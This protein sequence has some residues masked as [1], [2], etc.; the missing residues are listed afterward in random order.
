MA[1]A[2]VAVDAVT[3]RLVLPTVMVGAVAH[4]PVAVVQKPVPASVND[5]GVPNAEY[6]VT[7]EVI[8]GAAN[9]LPADRPKAA[10]IP[11]RT[12]EN[13]AIFIGSSLNHVPQ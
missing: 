11:R 13:E 7:I 3:V 2:V 6:P 9:A 8:E 5:V 12:G 4:A 10:A 1:V